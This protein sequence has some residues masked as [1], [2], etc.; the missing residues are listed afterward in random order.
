MSTSKD[1]FA[2][3]LPIYHST[4]DSSGEKR[5]VHVYLPGDAHAAMERSCRNYSEWLS[6]HQF[7]LNA[8][9][10]GTDLMAEKGMADTSPV[11]KQALI[12]DDLLAQL[13]ATNRMVDS[14]QKA[15][16]TA[17]TTKQRDLVKAEIQLAAQNMTDSQIASQLTDITR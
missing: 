6:F 3:P 14:Y 13:E 17:K 10:H 7:L 8:V 2:S 16:H 9:I 15:W 11:F 5:H 4:K 12:A 1:E